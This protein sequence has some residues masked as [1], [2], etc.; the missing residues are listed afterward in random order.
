[1]LSSEGTGK[2]RKWAIQT[3]SGSIEAAASDAA[4]ILFGVL[5]MII[6]EIEDHDVIHDRCHSVSCVGTITQRVEQGDAGRVDQHVRETEVDLCPAA[7][8][9]SSARTET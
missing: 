1:M 5:G 4:S 2:P 6:E 3:P 7:S 9:C 8:A